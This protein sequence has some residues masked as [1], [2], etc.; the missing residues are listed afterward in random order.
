MKPLSSGNIPKEIVYCVSAPRQILG[1]TSDQKASVVY[2]SDS[3]NK[4]TTATALNKSGKG[5]TKIIRTNDPFDGIKIFGYENY[6]TSIWKCFDSVGRVLDL[7]EQTLLD[8][9]VTEGISPDGYINGKYV[10]ARVGNGN[11]KLVRVGSSLYTCLLAASER[12]LMKPIKKKDLSPGHVYQ[13]KNGEVFLYVG[14]CYG[15]QPENI[16][17][18]NNF[19]TNPSFKRWHDWTQATMNK[20]SWS[21]DSYLRKWQTLEQPPRPSRIEVAYKKIHSPLWLKLNWDDE[22]TS[23]QNLQ[24]LENNKE[25]MWTTKNLF[26]SASELNNFPCSYFC[27]LTSNKNLVLEIGK[28]DIPNI[29]EQIRKLAVVTLFGDLK[30]NED[31]LK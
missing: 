10:W 8:I 7:T 13:Q 24:I 12:K 9:I 25:T 16:V 15:F 19:Q 17:N 3:T 30:Y 20:D 14:N 26:S 31:R 4:E 2:V 29:Y 5:S 28:L 11:M 23:E 22:R 27:H 18:N 21:K 6:T 1:G